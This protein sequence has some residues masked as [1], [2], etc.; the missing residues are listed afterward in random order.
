MWELENIHLFCRVHWEIMCSCVGTSGEW[1]AWSCYPSVFPIPLFFLMPKYVIIPLLHS[2]LTET[3]QKYSSACWLC[4]DP[5]CP[6][7]EFA[8]RPLAQVLLRSGGIFWPLNPALLSRWQSNSLLDLEQALAFGSLQWDIYCIKR[9]KHLRL[10]EVKS[11]GFPACHSHPEEAPK[12]LKHLCSP[13]IQLRC[14]RSPSWLLY[15]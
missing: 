10:V 14:T 4:A 6:W 1:W 11:K 9:G 3:I 13:C 7:Q 12:E 2:R 15:K 5:G 8:Q